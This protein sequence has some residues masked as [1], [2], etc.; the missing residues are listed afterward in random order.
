MTRRFTPSEILWP[1]DT[2]FL[3]VSALFVEGAQQQILNALWSGYDSLMAV[4]AGSD[5]DTRMEDVERTLTQLLEPHVR[6]ALTGDETF[7]CQHGVH[8]HETR[9]P[10]PAQPPL[11]DIGFVLRA[12]PR[13]VWPVETK[14]LK[15]ERWVAPYVA[16]VRDQFLTCRY[17]PFTGSGAMAAYLLSGCTGTVLENISHAL[18]ATMGSHPR[19]RADRHGVTDHLRAVPD[20]KLYPSAFRCHHLIMPIGT[21]T[22][23]G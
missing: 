6:D 15:T 23:P 17:A 5:L 4:V 8:E 12:N 10:A 3:E 2:G 7:Y 21:K 14:V 11:Y 1:S 9:L 19:F 20:G 13:I 16:D 22:G 18:G